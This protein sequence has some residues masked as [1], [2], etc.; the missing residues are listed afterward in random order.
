MFC[1]EGWRIWRVKWYI[2]HAG[3][4]CITRVSAR[5]YF[6]EKKFSRAEG[7]AEDCAEGELTRSPCEFDFG[8]ISYLHDTRDT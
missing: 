8:I 4:I 1:A 2:Q 6:F 7:C 5:M 3:S